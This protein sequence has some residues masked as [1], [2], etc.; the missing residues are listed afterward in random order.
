MGAAVEGASSSARRRRRTGSSTFLVP[1]APLY[2]R[3]A[4]VAERALATDP[5]WTL[6]SVRQ[7]GEAFAR[8]AA[9]RAGLLIAHDVQVMQVDLLRMVEQRGIVR[10]KLVEC[11]DMQ[12]RVGNAAVYDFVGSRQEALDGLSIA[13]HLAAWLRKTFGD[14]QARTAR[15]P[16]KYE[17]PTDPIAALCTLQE[18]AA[19]ARAE[20]DARGADAD[21]AFAASHSGRSSDAR[22]IGEAG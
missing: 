21:L 22:P 20:A 10:D 13:C 6:T 15:Q 3:L 7:L 4:T 8:H 17:P 16:P 12:R 14:K 5:S 1:D 11:F 9:A 19:E 2:L 18:D